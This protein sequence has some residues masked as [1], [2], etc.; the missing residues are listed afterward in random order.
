MARALELARY[1]ADQGE[2]PVGA[3]VVR[4]GVLL[5]EGRNQPIVSRD[6]TAHAEINALRAAGQAAGAYRL[7]GAT[8]YVTLEP[9][10]MCAGALI[11][12]RIER[13]VYGAADPKTG[14][15]GGQF[16]L[17]GLPGHNHR[18][19]VT[20]GVS[21]EAAAGLLREFFRARR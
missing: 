6:P 20:A 1:A 8:L 21:G 2:V 17:L 13:L 5:G 9:C 12:A 7:P 3:V 16:D 15:C 4:D 14:A 19:E 11:H 18:V 10:F